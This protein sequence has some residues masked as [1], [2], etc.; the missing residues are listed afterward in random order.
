MNHS[1]RKVLNLRL[2][3]NPETQKPWSASVTGI[4]GEILSVSQFTLFAQT[5]KGID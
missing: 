1:V 5:H 3:E 4:G 2:F